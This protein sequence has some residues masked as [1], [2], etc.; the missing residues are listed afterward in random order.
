MDVDVHGREA[1]VARPHQPVRLMGDAAR[2]ADPGEANGTDR[3]GRGTRRL[4]IQ[5][6]RCRAGSLGDGRDRLLGQHG[7]SRRS[8]RA[9][10]SEEHTSELQS[11]MRNSYAVFCLKKKKHAYKKRTWIPCNVIQT[12]HYLNTRANI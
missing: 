8:A 7:L 2:A 9:S 11:L 5:C 12:R 6:N 3:A 10:R 4:E 1:H